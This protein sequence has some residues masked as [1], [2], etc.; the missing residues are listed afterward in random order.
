MPVFPFSIPGLIDWWQGNGSGEDA[1]GSANATL[2]SGATYGPGLAG[3]AF[4]FNGT[5]SYVAIPSSADF[6]GTGAFSISVW[7]KTTSSSGV[8]IR[9]GLEQYNGEYQVS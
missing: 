2:E 7:I 3:Q 1:V 9:A 6:V 4:Q 5:S 8:I